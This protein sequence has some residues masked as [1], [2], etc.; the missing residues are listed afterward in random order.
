M[1]TFE[2]WLKKQ[3]HRNDSIGDLS[4]DFINTKSRRIV[5]AFEKFTPS[6]DALIAYKKAKKEYIEF[7]I[8]LENDDIEDPECELVF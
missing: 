8:E 5:K 1:I 6:Y 4:T 7:L 3:K 2:S